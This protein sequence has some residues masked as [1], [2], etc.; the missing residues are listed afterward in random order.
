MDEPFFDVPARGAASFAAVNAR[1]WSLKR[2]A[3]AFGESPR[4]SDE[5]TELLLALLER[6]RE[7]EAIHARKF[8]RKNLT[9][10]GHPRKAPDS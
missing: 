6:C 3:W 2:I 5:E 9:A 10:D 4:W 7:L 8:G 1:G